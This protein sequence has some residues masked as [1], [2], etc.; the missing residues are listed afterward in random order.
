[1][2]YNTYFQFSIFTDF[3]KYHMKKYKEIIS[4]PQK[5]LHALFYIK[6]V[7]HVL[8]TPLCS[9][10]RRCPSP[11]SHQQQVRAGQVAWRPL[12]QPIIIWRSPLHFDRCTGAQ[13]LF[14]EQLL[15]SLRWKQKSKNNNTMWRAGIRLEGVR[16]G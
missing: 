2:R 9:G 7:H 16:T 14:T 8:W 5:D 3:S 1:M 13:L 6:S 11:V 15:V 4:T 10:H 12:D